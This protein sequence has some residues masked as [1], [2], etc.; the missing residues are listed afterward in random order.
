[1]K[2]EA[3]LKFQP[4]SRTLALEP[5]LLYDAAAGAAVE[6]QHSQQQAQPDAARTAPTDA[7]AP[8]PDSHAATQQLLVIDARINGANELA[9]SATPGTRVVVVAAGQDGVAAIQA[10]LDQLGQVSSIQILGHGNPGEITLGTSQLTA[11]SADTNRTAEWASHLS[12]GADIL[13]YGCR[14]GAGDSGEALIQRLAAVTGADVAAST[15]DTGSAAAG[16]D[17]TLEK[18]IGPIESHLDINADELAHYNG[19]L[20]NAS[21]TT[22]LG[23]SGETILLGGT[24]TF[25]ATFTNPSSQ[26]GYAPYIDVLLPATGYDGDDGATFVSATYQGIALNAQII[27]FGAD[28]TAVHPIAKDASGNPLIL[29]AADYG[30]RAG[31]Q[32]VV[33]ELPYASFGN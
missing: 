13:L 9:Q 12:A 6:Q 14:R 1:M 4:S 8:A 11:A 30:Y 26:P 23:S 24:A 20:A 22:T 31:D 15:N 10:A 28:G 5:R 7:H 21:P 33:L 27:T 17:W 16:G 32:L 19:L 18:S 2:P 3:A 29:R 25:E